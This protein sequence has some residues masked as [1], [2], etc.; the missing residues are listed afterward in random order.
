MQEKNNEIENE[1][2]NEESKP[3]I[4]PE[5]IKNPQNNNNG[6][7]NFPINPS[8]NE[9]NSGE[10]NKI[11]NNEDITIKKNNIN[12]NNNI[13]DNSFLNFTP[14]KR[15]IKTLNFDNLSKEQKMEKIENF[16]HSLLSEI[17]TIK[18]KGNEFYNNKNFEAAEK[19]YNEGIKKINEY[20]ILQDID[21]FNSKINDYL[22]NINTLNL[23]LYNNLSAVF[24]KL[25]KYEEVIQNCRF[26][27]ENLNQEHVLSYYRIL[28]SLIKLKKVILANHYADIIKTKFGNDSSFAKFQDQLE[29]LEILNREF[30]DKILNQKPELKK[31]V[32][33]MNDIQIKKEDKKEEIN[34]TKYIPYIIVG[35]V[36]LFAGGRFLYKNLKNK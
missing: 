9:S 31:E 30:S 32:I 35:A 18:E 7:N 20:A 15:N 29:K 3:E 5:L 22:I 8:L 21:E 4:E 10:D 24:I 2:N 1:N 23:Q 13:I 36:I 27:V 26:I 19:Q 25:E 28:F 12:N 17:S 14:L 16:L 11:I 6:E 34:I 33:S